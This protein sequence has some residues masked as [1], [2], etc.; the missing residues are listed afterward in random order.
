MSVQAILLPVFVQILLIFLLILSMAQS[1]VRAINSKKVRIKDIALRQPNWPERT[2][3]FAN[4]F[5]NQLELPVLFFILV[6]FAMITQKADYLFVA[7]SWVFVLFRYLQAYI[8]V[9]SNNVRMRSLYFAGGCFVL[10]GMWMIF[11]LKI[12]SA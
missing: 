2:T 1:R 10:M 12:Y 8:F 5:H 7:L 4:A 6:A 9:T 11:A 3:V